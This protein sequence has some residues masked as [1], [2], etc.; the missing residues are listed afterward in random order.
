MTESGPNF[1]TNS[2]IWPV[3]RNL[4]KTVTYDTT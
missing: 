1:V 2:K 3:N 4:M